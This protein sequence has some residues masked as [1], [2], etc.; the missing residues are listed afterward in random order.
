M[1]PGFGGK[2]NGAGASQLMLEDVT[3]NPLSWAL[4]LYSHMHSLSGL[5]PPRILAPILVSSIWK[6]GGE[7]A[8]GPSRTTTFMPKLQRVPLCAEGIPVGSQRGLMAVHPPC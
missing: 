5:S 1:S 7:I 8:G 4:W 6:A 3:H 2:V